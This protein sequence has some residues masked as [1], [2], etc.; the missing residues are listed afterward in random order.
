[1]N[2]EI[3]IIIPVYNEAAVIEKTL[4][5]INC[6]KKAFNIEVIV[7][8]GGSN[9][10]TVAIA[11]KYATVIKTVKGKA[12]QLNHAASVSTGQ[13]LFFVHA[14]MMVSSEAV[15]AILKTVNERGFDGGGFDNV[16]DVENKRIKLINALIF[17]S[18]FEKRRKK[19]EQKKPVLYGDNGIFV[20]ASVFNK[21]GGFKNIPIME[22]YDLSGRLNKNYKILKLYQPKLILSSRRF[23]KNGIFFTTFAWLLIQKL[24]K[25]GIS[26]N[27][28]FKLYKDVR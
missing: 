3:S 10:S 1:M 9:D 27:F 22:D 12:I 28:L 19:I 8:D 6:I 16:F 4:Q 14:D 5:Q 13:I 2:P 7:A 15:K 21:I 20:K 25:A 18:F 11:K 24:Y 17:L 26:P 23:L